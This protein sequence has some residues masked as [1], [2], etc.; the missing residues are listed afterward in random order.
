MCPD[1]ST[2]LKHDFVSLNVIVSVLRDVRER[3]DATADEGVLGRSLVVE[4]AGVE[5]EE[6]TFVGN[7]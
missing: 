7:S 2:C 1:V 5:F 6:G 3:D 4:E